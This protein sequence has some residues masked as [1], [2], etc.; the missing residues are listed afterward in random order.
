MTKKSDISKNQAQCA[1]PVVTCCCGLVIPDSEIEY[2]NR[3]NEEGEEY[4][5]G[6]AD[7][8][9]GKEYEWSE[10]GECESLTEAK[11]DLIEHISN[12]R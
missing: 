5:E 11:E 2:S 3:C 8:K 6:T 7:C 10:W 12:C 9:C 4:Y 1:I